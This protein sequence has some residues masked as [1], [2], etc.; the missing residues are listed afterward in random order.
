MYYRYELQIF[1]VKEISVSDESDFMFWNFNTISDISMITLANT[2]SSSPLQMRQSK[3][4]KK[5]WP[6]SL[7]RTRNWLIENHPELL[8]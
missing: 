8:I 2:S 7:I 5:L 3:N 1:G 6:N 4:Q